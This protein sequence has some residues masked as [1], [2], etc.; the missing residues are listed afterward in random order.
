M[1]DLSPVPSHD[2][3]KKLKGLVDLLEKVSNLDSFLGKRQV[4]DLQHMYAESKGV[5]ND[6]IIMLNS[7]Y[8]L[9]MNQCK[10]MVLDTADPSHMDEQYDAEGGNVGIRNI[11]RAIKFFNDVLEKHSQ[12]KGWRTQVVIEGVREI[13]RDLA[14]N[15]YYTLDDKDPEISQ[16]FE[17]KIPSIT[18][19]ATKMES[20]MWPVLA[21][22]TALVEA[23]ADAHP[24]L[25]P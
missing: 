22:L 5:H 13:F 10:L 15:E 24:P 9:C 12:F 8:E 19:S 4:E 21:R 18:A 1:A 11:N 6:K 2:D 25:Q 16:L 7:V 3:D 23:L 20:S 17:S 14:K